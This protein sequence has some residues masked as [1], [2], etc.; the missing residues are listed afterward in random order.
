MHAVHPRDT[1]KSILNDN[2]DIF[3]QPETV[4]IDSIDRHMLKQV[5]VAPRSHNEAIT[6]RHARHA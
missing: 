2:Y 3:T 4:E 5:T 6:S 1:R